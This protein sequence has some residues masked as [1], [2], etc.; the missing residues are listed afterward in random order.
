MLVYHSWLR[1]CFKIVLSLL[2]STSK[3]Y[4]LRGTTATAAE[5]LAVCIFLARRYLEVTYLNILNTSNFSLN[6]CGLFKGQ[7]QS[8]MNTFY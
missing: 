7:V 5:L 4:M 3:E 1:G 8:H 6:I 2:S